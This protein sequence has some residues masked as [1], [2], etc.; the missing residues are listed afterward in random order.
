MARPKEFD[1]ETA[2]QAAVKVFAE[3]GYEGTSTDVLL[4]AMGISRQ[5]MYDTFGDKRRLYLEALQ[6]YNADSVADIIRALGAGSS[7]LE[8]LE[9]ALLAFASRT[10]ADDKTP[11]CMGVSAICEFGRS[12]PEV[13]MLTDSSS[14]TLTSA[15]ERILTEAKKAK[16]VGPD[17]EVRSAARFLNATLAGMRVSARGG[18]PTD[19]LRDIARMA[20]RSLR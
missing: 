20:L 19:E 1:R 17:V 15:L 18:T 2:L 11:G 6:H 4:R 12:D 13:N 9:K 3:H 14:R 5:S 8:G 7:P 10:G 16:A